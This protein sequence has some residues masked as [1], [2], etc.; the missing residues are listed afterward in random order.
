MI[1][2]ARKCRAIIVVHAGKIVKYITAGCV[3]I[4]YVAIG[5]FR[6]VLGHAR[7]DVIHV[8][9]VLVVGAIIILMK[10]ISDWGRIQERRIG[11]CPTD[12][13]LR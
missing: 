8:D 3:V 10:K 13:L 9:T 5:S 11:E 4:I 7:K 1:F 12:A 6:F 2:L